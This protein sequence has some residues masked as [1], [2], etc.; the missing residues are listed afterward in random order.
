MANLG[1]LKVAANGEREIVMTRV[2]DAP[3]ELVFSAMTKPEL[4]Q[5]W[6]LGPD[7]WSMP[8]CEVD[9]KVG[10]KYRYVWRNIA[11]GAEMGMGG[12]YR[13]IVAP[14]RIVATE[15][16]EEASSGEAL[17]TLILSEQAGKTTLTQTISCESRE[18]RDAILKSGMEKGVAASYTRLD[19]V[20]ASMGP[21]AKQKGANE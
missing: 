1:E 9:L 12:V 5:R 2:F 4:L 10:G 8:V 7:G 18:M 17:N 15:K 20:L 6:L 14:E 16:F 19:D 3:R 21:R 13:E 11:S